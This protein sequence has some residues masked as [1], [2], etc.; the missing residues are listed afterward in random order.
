MYDTGKVYSGTTFYIQIGCTDDFRRGFNDIQ[1]NVV[2]HVGCSRYLALVDAGISML[3]VLD[4]QHPVFSLRLMNGPKALIRRVCVSAN[5]QQMYVPMS[6]PRHLK[7]HRLIAQ[8]LDSAVQIGR[9][10]QQGGDVLGEG[11]V[12]IGTRIAGLLQIDAVA[13]EAGCKLGGECVAAGA[14]GL[15]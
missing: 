4:L 1:V 11:L 9:L 15:V 6:H 12:E 5:C 10:A 7:Q 8:I 13:M 14:A 2:T 3:R